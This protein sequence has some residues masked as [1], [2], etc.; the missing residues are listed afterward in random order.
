METRTLTDSR[1]RDVS[2]SA[3]LSPAAT[4]PSS[5]ITKAGV[6]STLIVTFLESRRLVQ[7]LGMVVLLTLLGLRGGKIAPP[8]HPRLPKSQRAYIVSLPSLNPNSRNT[9]G[10]HTK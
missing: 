1:K 7:C 2:V 4:S 3:R 6:S 5:Q 8:T 9:H 10:K